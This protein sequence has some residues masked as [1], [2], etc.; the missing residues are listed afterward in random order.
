MRTTL[1]CALTMAMVAAL[2][3][4]QPGS[5]GRGPVGMPPGG[6]GLSAGE[7]QQLNAWTAQHMPN[8]RKLLDEPPPRRMRFQSAA[9]LR[10]RGYEQAVGNADALERIVKG[11]KAE[12]A[13]YGLVVE[14]TQA[15]EDQRA[16]I[17]DKIRQA[18]QEMV[19]R[20]LKERE[21]RLNELKKRLA[22][23]EE[24]V[25]RDR[26]Q[27]QQTVDRIF[28]SRYRLYNQPGDV[29]AAPTTAP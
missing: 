14:L 28:N 4:A 24:A 19:E 13:I 6:R 20:N 21:Q 26:A 16:A 23:E 25:K 10:K 22:S 5:P 15:P 17:N 18:T 11:F 8:L 29:M 27:A 7:V 12:D 1:F 2:A 9:L 3:S